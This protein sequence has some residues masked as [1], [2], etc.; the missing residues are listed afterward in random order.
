[1]SESLGTRLRRRR[2][3]QGISLRSIADRT[4]IKTSLLEGLERDDT[5]WWPSGL[6]RRAY[7]RSYAEA[8]G[9]D[10]GPALREFLAAH[11]DPHEHVGVEARAASEA[12]GTEGAPPT[13]LGILVNRM[14]RTIAPAR[15]ADAMPAGEARQGST[16]RLEPNPDADAAAREPLPDAGMPLPPASAAVPEPEDISAPDVFEVDLQ[17][18]AHL[19]TAFACA[20]LDDVDEMQH[21]LEDTARV[22]GASGLMVWFWDRA[23]ARLW[24]ALAHGYRRRLLEQV[25]AIDRDADN[26]TAA[27]FRSASAVA[28]SDDAHGALVVPVMTPAGCAG[29]LA[30]E[31]APGREKSDAVLAVATV[32]AGLIGHLVTEAA[33]RIRA[34]GAGPSSRPPRAVAR[35]RGAATLNVRPVV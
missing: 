25:P 17:S 13:R 14:L 29:V 19:S 15:R 12:V 3:E 22:V 8:I 2:E 7:F 10:A 9:I 21:V 31:L 4:K 33:G 18:L 5:S 11:P 24:P 6:F 1:M 34:V 32:I 30:L 16:V 26:A 23:A 20:R 27:A 35:R 28:V